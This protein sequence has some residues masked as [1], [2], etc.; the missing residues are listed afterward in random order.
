MNSDAIFT[1]SDADSDA[2]WIESLGPVEMISL[3]PQSGSTL[4]PSFIIN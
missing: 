4:L 3:D 1:G 2:D